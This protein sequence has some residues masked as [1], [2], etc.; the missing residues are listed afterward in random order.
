MPDHA[1]LLRWRPD[2]VHQ[3]T[4]PTHDTLAQAAHHA[5]LVAIAEAAEVTV[6]R[7]DRT[8]VATV[9]CGAPS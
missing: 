6:L 2:W 4:I 8:P 7:G 3:R 9:R 1:Y 5:I